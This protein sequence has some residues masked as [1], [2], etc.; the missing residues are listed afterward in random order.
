MHQNYTKELEVKTIA[1]TLVSASGS[2]EATIIE[3]SISYNQNLVSIDL[4][5]IDSVSEVDNV[6]CAMNIYLSDNPQSF[7]NTDEMYVCISFFDSKPV[8]SITNIQDYYARVGNYPIQSGYI[9]NDVTRDDLIDQI[10]ILTSESF[11]FSVFVN[12]EAEYKRIVLSQAV[13][14]DSTDSINMIKG[15]ESISL[16]EV[17]STKMDPLDYESYASFCNAFNQF[18]KDKGYLFAT[19]SVNQNSLSSWKETYGEECPTIDY[20]MNPY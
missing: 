14:L 7:I 16:C 1:T 17:S 15:L 10:Q 5:G 19:I 6:V 11:P 13:I 3:T 12:C 9:T 20:E 2:D 18:N 8:G 4:Y